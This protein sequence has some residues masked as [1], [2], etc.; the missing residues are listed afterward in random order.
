VI[1]LT[2]SAIG[3]MPVPAWGSGY[4]GLELARD[5]RTDTEARC[6]LRIFIPD[7]DRGLVDHV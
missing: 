6:A 5:H 7:G 4:A 3:D 2:A 1:A